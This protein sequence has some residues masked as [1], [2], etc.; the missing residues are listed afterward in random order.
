[1]ER[2]DFY[3]THEPDPD[4]PVETT[5]AVLGDLVREGK[6]GA[7]GGSNVDGM[8]LRTASGYDFVQNSYSLLDRDP[9]QD[10]LPLCVER[11]LGF[12]AFSPL[13]G[14]WLTGKYRRGEAPAPGS[15]MS[16]RPE[17]YVHLDDERVYRGLDRLEARARQRG[18]STAAVA[19]AWLLGDERVDAVVLGPRRPEHLQPALDALD[20]HLDHEEREELALF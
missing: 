7:V 12:Q 4:T 6:V 19:F 2:V 13:A 15:R 11:G 18:T 5:L 14:G 1:V 9:E 17:P 10:V 20:L 16:Q 3:L 8:L